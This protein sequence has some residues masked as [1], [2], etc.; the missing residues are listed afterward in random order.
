MGRMRST[1]GFLKPLSSVHI[2]SLKEVLV[3][4]N[5]LQAA[6]LR[7]AGQAYLSI[8]SD[9]D[10][11]ITRWLRTPVTQE[12]VK[13][14]ASGATTLRS[15][16]MNRK[17]FVVDTD[18]SDNTLAEYWVSYENLSDADLPQEG[19]YLPRTTS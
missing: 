17:V 1:W 3:Y 19:G 7:E 9:E 12:E 8:A 5:G 10:H 15:C 14:L 2:W 6:I 4:F 18:S 11:G 16:F 13:G